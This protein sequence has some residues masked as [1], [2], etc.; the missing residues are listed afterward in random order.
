MKNCCIRFS[1]LCLLLCAEVAPAPAC[2]APAPEATVPVIM[3]GETAS[4]GTL[5]DG[6]PGR[7]II[8]RATLAAKKLYL[9]AHESQVLARLEVKTA[10]EGIFFITYNLC[11]RN[12]AFEGRSQWVAVSLFVDGAPL[13]AVGRRIFPISSEEFAW[14]AST[15]IRQPAGLHTFELSARCS[16]VGTVFAGDGTELFIHFIPVSCVDDPE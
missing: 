3:A 9:K 16:G 13:N 2:A 5:K 7:H 8:R 6:Q 1:F 12:G 15:M 4:E 11:G 14:S 10:E